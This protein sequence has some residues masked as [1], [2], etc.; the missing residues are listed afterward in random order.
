MTTCIIEKREV[1]NKSRSFRLSDKLDKKIQV[2]S[3]MY[4]DGDESGWIRHCIE[5]YTPR[6][7]KTKKAVAKKKPAKKAAPKKT[8]KKKAQ[9]KGLSGKPKR[10][11]KKS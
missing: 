6:V 2:M 4:A 11:S 8:A 5:N 10:P 9:K 3:K 7:L 1:F